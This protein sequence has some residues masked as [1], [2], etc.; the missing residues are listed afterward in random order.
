[1]AVPF[2]TQHPSLPPPRPGPLGYS[3]TFLPPLAEVPGSPV[4]TRVQRGELTRRRENGTVF[5]VFWAPGY[6]WAPPVRG[7]CAPLAK[8][9]VPKQLLAQ[10]STQTQ[11]RCAGSFWRSSSCP[12]C[13]AAGGVERRIIEKN[14]YRQ[15]SRLAQTHH[16]PASNHREG[17]PGTD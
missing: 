7:F 10:A 16:A 4:A 9:L 3:P 2:P 6:E 15:S 14:A 17:P 1:M 5:A 12:A 11:P 8:R 13:T